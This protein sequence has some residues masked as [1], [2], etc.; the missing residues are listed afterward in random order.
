MAIQNGYTTIDALRGRLGNGGNTASEPF[1]EQVI[2]AASR[3][4]D[5]ICNRQFYAATGAKVFTAEWPDLLDID[6]L[7]NLTTLETDDQND[8]TYST[9]WTVTDYELEPANNASR[10]RP[11]T[12]IQ[13]HPQTTKAF[14]TTRRGV[15]ITGTWGWPAIPSPVEEACLLIAVRLNQ[16]AKAPF[17]TAGTVQDGAVQYTPRVDPVVRQLLDPYRR[18][19]IGAVG[20]C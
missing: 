8:R 9:L 18:L 12:S 10:G 6:D 11:Y 20:G 15:R 14:P 19:N 1:L 16:S 3:E 4:I 13:L 5:G 17:G 2:E 7:T